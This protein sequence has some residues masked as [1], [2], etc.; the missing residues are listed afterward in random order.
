MVEKRQDDQFES[1]NSN[2][3]PIRDLALKTCQKQWAIGR[4]GARGPG[5]SALIAQH[6]DDDDDD[7]DDDDEDLKF[8]NDI[9]RLC[10]LRWDIFKY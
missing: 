4:V 5:I 7:D 2:S 9:G 6:N 3:V 1:T 10:L 8:I